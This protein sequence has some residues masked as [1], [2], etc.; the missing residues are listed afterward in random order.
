VTIISP[1]AGGIEKN[2]VIN[3]IAS[4]PN[5]PNSPYQI[6]LNDMILIQGTTDQIG[7]IN[8][9]ISGAIQGENLLQVKVSNANNEIIGESENI[10][11]MYSPIADGTFNSIQVL[12]SNRIKQGTQVEFNVSTNDSVTSAQIRLSNGKSA[13]MDRINAGLFNKKLTIDTDGT[14]EIS[15]DLI[16]AG[17][18]KSYTGVTSIFV[19]KS[20]TIG[21]IRLYADSIDKT[22]LNV[23]RETV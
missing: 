8:T 15:L 22:K 23:T 21:K 18:T 11:F 17:Q 12:P 1:A 19:E 20:I 16:T 3:V 10:R 14:I 13:P 2:N 9:Y 5:L 6:Y 4:A 7:D